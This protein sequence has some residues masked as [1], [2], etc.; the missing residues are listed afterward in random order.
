MISLQKWDNRPIYEQIRDEY[1]RRIIT[2]AIR[3]DERLPSVRELSVALTINLNTIQRAYRELEQDGYSYSIPGK[4][5]FAAAGAN[6]D[7][8]RHGILLDRLRDVTT[9]LR[10]LGADEAEIQK[11]VTEGVIAT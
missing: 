5:S 2:G 3:P 6:V 1:R 11:A 9:E 10:Y 7:K 8:R 4:G